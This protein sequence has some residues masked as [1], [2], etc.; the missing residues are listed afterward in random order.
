MSVPPY[1]IFRGNPNKDPMWLEAVDRVATA[2]S[3]MVE[4]ALLKPGPYF[5]FCHISR[6]VLATID[7]S[8]R[9]AAHA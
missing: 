8:M 5:I 4:H 6:T 7:T 1:D 3:R 9:D 2:K